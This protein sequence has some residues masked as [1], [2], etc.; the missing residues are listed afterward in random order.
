M[1][2]PERAGDVDNTTEPEP[3]EVVVPVPPFATARVPVIVIVP[4]VVTGPP[5]NVRPVAPPDT[6]T[7]VT[8]PAVVQVGVAPAPAD[9]RT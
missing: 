1:V 2:A 3:V 8:V 9:V 7:E 4:E 6:C 5:L